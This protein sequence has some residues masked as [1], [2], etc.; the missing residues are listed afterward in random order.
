MAT[1]V[2]PVGYSTPYTSTTTQNSGLGAAAAPYGQ[3]VLAQSY[4]LASQDPYHAYTG[5]TVAGPTGL[6]QTAA[7]SVSGLNAGALATQGTALTTQGANYTPANATFDGAAA[8]QY[9]NPYQQN[10]ID[11]ANKEAGRQSDL[12]GVQQAGQ[13]AQA[14]AFGGSRQGV[15]DA[16]R[17]RTLSLLQNNNEMQ[18]QAAAYTNA[19]Q[20]FNADQTRNQQGNQYASQAALAGGN[21]LTNQGAQAFGQQQVSGAQQQAQAQGDLT[22]DKANFTGAVQHPYDQ[23]NFMT[24][25]I[26]AM[27]GSS[28]TTGTTYTPDNTA[29]QP[30]G[31]Q[32]AASTVGG[33]AGLASAGTQLWNSVGS[34]FAKGGAVP[35]AGLRAGLPQAR[36]AQLYGKM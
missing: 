15:V 25:Q 20:Q 8:Q 1:P 9:M 10:V 5:Q 19:Q 14:G 18:G 12:Q 30:T 26:K 7:D 29:N 23:L 36:I 13:A 17:Q 4:A 32:Q 3:D 27:P 22:Q 28:T 2:T 24:N 34:F 33:L 11:V 6:Q 31:V 21:A 16:E 35:P